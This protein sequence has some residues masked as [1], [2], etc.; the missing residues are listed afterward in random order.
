MGSILQ[1]VFFYFFASVKILSFFH[2]LYNG[3]SRKALKFKLRKGS[4]V[5]K[6]YLHLLFMFTFSIS[7]W[8]SE[9][10]TLFVV[11]KVSNAMWYIHAKSGCGHLNLGHQVRGEFKPRQWFPN[12][13]EW[14]TIRAKNF[15]I[16]DHKKIGGLLCRPFGSKCSAKSPISGPN[17]SCLDSKNVL[18]DHFEKW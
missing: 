2:V 8:I 7:Q 14:R 17:C 18:E 11:S 16:T 9:E 10:L 5:L 3:L 12:F 13:F 15:L 6:A 4:V 1:S